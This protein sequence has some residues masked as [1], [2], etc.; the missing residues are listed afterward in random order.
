MIRRPPRST[1]FPYTTLFR[2]VVIAGGAD[3]LHYTSA[4]VFD[5]V[6]AASR[7]YNDAPDASPRPFDDARDGLVVSEGAGMVVL[8]S[9][10]SVKSRGARPLAEILSGAYLCDGT[11]MSQP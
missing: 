1:L 7:K 10:A 5:V 3:E 11:H 4:A 6:Q 2:S 9:E 8:E